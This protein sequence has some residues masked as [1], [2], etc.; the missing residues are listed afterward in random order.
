[1]NVARLGRS[2]RRYSTPVWRSCHREWRVLYITLPPFFNHKI[3]PEIVVRLPPQHCVQGTRASSYIVSSWKWHASSRATLLW[4][5]RVT[6]LVTQHLL[7]RCHLCLSWQEKLPLYWNAR[8]C[9]FAHYVV[10]FGLWELM[11]TLSRQSLTS[12]ALVPVLCKSEV[13][14]DVEECLVQYTI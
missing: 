3:L 4:C 10:I 12:Q 8:S 7:P 2:R 13:G 14:G 5:Y 9:R 1:M 6:W 11:I